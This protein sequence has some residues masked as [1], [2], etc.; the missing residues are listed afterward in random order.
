M[1]TYV[2]DIEVLLKNFIPYQE[3]L[4]TIKEEKQDFSDKIEGIKDEM[5]KILDTSQSLILGNQTQEDK[6]AKFDAL[7]KEGVQIQSEFQTKIV[8]LQESELNR[9]LDLVNEIVADWA[10]SENI[11][12]IANKNTMLYVSDK[13]DATERI[14]S[15]IKSKDKFNE[16]NEEDYILHEP[17]AQ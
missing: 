4:L 11:A 5:R 16:F 10:K 3:S 6:K 9:N 1:E 14:L 13:F 2:A 17:V 15:V 12:C 8:E 7:Q